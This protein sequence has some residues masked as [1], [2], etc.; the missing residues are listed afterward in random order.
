MSSI[1]SESIPVVARFVH[2]VAGLL[3]TAIVLVFVVF[4]IG[5]GAPAVLLLRPQTWALL[6][7]L[8]GFVLVW[9]RDLAGGVISLFGIGAFYLLNYLEAER[10]PGGWV[11]PLCFLPGVLAVA[12]YL[13]Q[14]RTQPAHH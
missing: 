12:A 6:V 5:E 9:W 10:F 7:M 14:T 4:A 11:F 1:S 13:M 2:W 8:V 3:G